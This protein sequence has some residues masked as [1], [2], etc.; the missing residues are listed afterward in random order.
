MPPGAPVKVL[1]VDDSAIMQKLMVSM[2]ST[3]ARLQVVGLASNGEECIQ[4]AVQLQ[5]QVILLDLEMPVLSGPET[6]AELKRRA[7]PVAVLMVCDFSQ[8][9]SPNLKIALDA[10]AVDFFV[11]PKST[12]EIDKYQR[13][14]LTKIFV[15]SMKVSKTVPQKADP[16]AAPSPVA[17]MAAVDQR[18][19]RKFTVIGCSTGGK[20]SLHALL[21]LLT[22]KCQTSILIV[23]QQPAFIVQQF[24]KELKTTCKLPVNLVSENADLLP[25]NVLIAPAGNTDVVVERFVEAGG[26]VYRVHFADPTQSSSNHPSLDALFQSAASAMGEDCMGVVLSGTGK[27][28]IVGLKAIQSRKGVTI[29]ED[30]AT[31]T[32]SQLSLEAQTAKAVDEVLPI[33]GIAE[34]LNS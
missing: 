23:M 1:V 13:Q 11:K 14:V 16:N 6:M 18:R 24:L 12:L 8:K 34:R 27:D 3:D 33:K 4:K 5:P 29:A 31:A 32:V 17:A 10:G 26:A 2:L 22:E 28:G 9:E 25:R 20:Q 7:L 15:A 21:P 30:K 19:S